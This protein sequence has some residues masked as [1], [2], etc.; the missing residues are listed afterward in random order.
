MG[1]KKKVADLRETMAY[2]TEILRDER[3]DPAE[4]LRA[5]GS[6]MRFQSKQALLEASPDVVI[7]DDIPDCTQCPLFKGGCFEVRN[8]EGR[9][10]ERALSSAESDDD[11]T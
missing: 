1:R 11:E 4:R 3:L 7:V 10:R 9:L 8:S 6:L 2:L 5:G